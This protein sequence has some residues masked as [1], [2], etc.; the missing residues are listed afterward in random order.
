[1]LRQWLL[2]SFWQ[3]YYLNAPFPI[4]RANTIN[5][6]R[7]KRKRSLKISALRQYPVRTLVYELGTSLEEMAVVI[8]GACEE[9]QQRNIP[10]NL[11]IADRGGRVF[12]MPQ[13]IEGPLCPSIAGHL[14]CPG[15]AGR[16]YC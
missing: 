2:Y 1:M 8:A 13:V 14:L 5:V 16:A 4:E 6:M 3:A 9:L 10:F 12:L 15:A 11:L 7:R